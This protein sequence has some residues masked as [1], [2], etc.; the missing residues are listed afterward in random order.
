MSN[1]I[2]SLQLS[3]LRDVGVVKISSRRL[4]GVMV[5]LPSGYSAVWPAC[6]P[7]LLVACVFALGV[8]RYVSGSVE[9]GIGGSVVKM[10]VPTW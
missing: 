6:L 2:G 4:S 10:F 7:V 1:V 3:M 8:F 5:L 9:D